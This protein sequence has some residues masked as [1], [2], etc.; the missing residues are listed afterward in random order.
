MC[1]LPRFGADAQLLGETLASTMLA[2]RRPGPANAG[3]RGGSYCRWL[4]GRSG[5]QW[6]SEW[7]GT[8]VPG[9]SFMWLE[10]TGRCQLQCA[11]CYADS[12]P[13]G[14]H[15]VMTAADWRRVID[16]AAG[17]G[18]SMVQFIGGEPT[19][20]PELPEL[21]DHTLAVGVQVEVFSNLVHV[22]PALGDTFDRPGVRLACS[23]YSDDPAQHVAVTAESARTFAPAPTSSRWYVGRSRC[24]SG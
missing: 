1:S 9:V 6:S 13:Y 2:H 23:Y 11:H 16:Q 24:G 4:V 22:T 10:V 18:V 12:G 8:A 15:E 3:L 21:V 20:Y 5:R 14:M 17:I 19:L 7:K